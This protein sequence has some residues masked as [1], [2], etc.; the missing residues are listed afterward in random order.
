MVSRYCSFTLFLLV[1]SVTGTWGQIL[2]FHKYSI[3]DGLVSNSVTT[4]M[5]DSRGFIWIG[6]M[7]GISVYDGAVFKNY[8]IADGL[9]FSR[10]NAIIE[11]NK[12]PGTMWIATNGG[13]ICKFSHGRFTPYRV[14]STTLSDRVNSLLE[15]H[16]GELWC[17]TDGGLFRLTGDSLVPFSKEYSGKDFEQLFEEGDSLIWMLSSYRT[18]LLSEQTGTVRPFEAY[19]HDTTI[20]Y[21][22]ANDHAGN[23]WLCTIDSALIEVRG[24]EVV[25]KLRLPHIQTLSLIEDSDGDFW[26]GSNSGLIR[27]TAPA[28]SSPSFS[29]YV[30]QNGLPDNYIYAGLRDRENNLWFFSLTEALLKLSNRALT[31][32]PIST[33]AEMGNNENMVVDHAGHVWVANGKT[34][35][36]FWQRTD[37]HWQETEH[38]LQNGHTTYE[39]ASLQLDN[40][41][42]LWVRA[43]PG[44][45]LQYKIQ[46]GTNSSSTLVL[47]RTLRQG[48]DF[49][50][51][52][53]FCFVI[54][55]TDRLWVSCVGIGVVRLDLNRPKEKFR[56]YTD[57][58]GLPDPGVWVMHV[59]RENKIWT[60]TY[61]SGAA[62]FNDSSDRFI[63]FTT[64]QGLPDNSVRSIFEDSRGAVWIG[65]RYGGLAMLM[66]GKVTV[67]TK[68]NGL[69]SNAITS[70]AEDSIHRLWIGTISGMQSMSLDEP[71]TFRSNTE[72]SGTL[73]YS[74]LTTKN[75]FLFATSMEGVTL[76]DFSHDNPG[77]V[78]PPIY[79]TSF[80]VNEEPVT[81]Q[82]EITLRSNQNNCVIDFVGL[83]FRDEGETR[84]R[85]Q[86]LPGDDDWRQ[87]MRER[88][89]TFAALRPGTYT[90]GVKA[91]NGAGV[92]SIVPAVI[93]FTVQP[94]IWQTWW[95]IAGVTV[96]IGAVIAIAVRIREQ[97]IIAMERVRSRIASDLHDDVGSGLVRIALLSEVIQRQVTSEQKPQAEGKSSSAFNVASASQNVGTIAREL[98]D[99]MNDVVWSIDPRNDTLEQYL[100]R[101]EAFTSE[102][103][104]AVGV[105]VTFE[106]DVK[107]RSMNLGIAVV[108]CLLLVSKEAMTNIVRHAKC[109]SVTFRL[110]QHS[111]PSRLEMS[112]TDDGRGFDM[113]SLLRINGL[114]NMKTRAEKIGATLNVS[115]EINKGTTISMIIPM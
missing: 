92:E 56:L 103:C 67:Y 52:F 87:P 69:F 95:F 63:P 114:R 32:F 50:D 51:R 100:R 30:V 48:K 77:T 64:S 17:G 53:P 88:S 21:S 58:D 29:N 106:V 9:P 81:I 54:D 19:P 89:V 59:D 23:L 49:P 28:S 5:Q 44:S 112:I 45:I 42:M 82:R 12:H 33:T 75:G 55:N 20:V 80:R 34:L 10:I 94:P 66:N 99:A 43:Q 3:H 108:R 73:Y 71:G 1:L 38:L 70:I 47:S 93:T 110:I 6:G 37:Q 26:C 8:T 13:G 4:I 14:G 74:C 101:I 68:N 15:D 16:T 7:D 65:T 97:Q 111:S 18:L 60:G 107:D 79:I 40:E 98:V 46:S 39:P 31:R 113:D 41:G 115:S 72:L 104:D 22:M 102:L 83:S 90:F 84:Y 24:T 57:R 91:I 86:L 61:I 76:Y 85:Y 62:V 105:A 27:I 109:R 36:E 96:L 35:V 11:S 2:P 78:P 25:R